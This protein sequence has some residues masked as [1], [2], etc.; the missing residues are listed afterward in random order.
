MLTKAT[1]VLCVLCL[2]VGVTVCQAGTPSQSWNRQADWSGQAGGNPASDSYGNAGVWL[3]ELWGPHSQGADALSG[4]PWYNDGPTAPGAWFDLG[5]MGSPL[6]GWGC[7]W[8][9]GW[10]CL[11][12]TARKETTNECTSQCISRW[13]CIDTGG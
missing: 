3:Y 6:V 11:V 7:C 10:R 1:S 8:W 13:D 12:T 9:V 4:F 5:S 2:L